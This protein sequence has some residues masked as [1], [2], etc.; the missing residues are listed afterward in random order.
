MLGKRLL[1]LTV[2]WRL[3]CSHPALDPLWST[4]AVEVVHDGA[5]TRRVDKVAALAASP[6]ALR[7]LRVCWENRGGAYNCGRCGKCM[8][9]MVDLDLAGALGHTVDAT[10]TVSTRD[11][12]RGRPESVMAVS[13][14]K[15][16]SNSCS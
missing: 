1:N 12:P 16:V 5:E 6:L 15:T 13:S 11:T 14:V 2:T 9:T 7:Y 3:P 4:E 8:R 10:G